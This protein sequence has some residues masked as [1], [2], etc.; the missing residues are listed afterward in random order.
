MVQWFKHL[1]AAVLVSEEA[2]VGSLAPCS[3]LKDPVLLQLQRRSNPGPG[4]SIG[5]RCS[6]K[7]KYKI[8]Y[9]IVPKNIWQINTK[10]MT[11]LFLLEIQQLIFPSITVCKEAPYYSIKKD[12]IE[13]P[14]KDQMGNF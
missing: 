10:H 5:S 12:S 13:K 9:E 2:W 3:R 8:K 6:H 4:I 14:A 7:I 11:V 1:T